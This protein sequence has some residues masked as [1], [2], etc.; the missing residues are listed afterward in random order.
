MPDAH[1]ADPDSKD[2]PGT[3][4]PPAPP[5]RVSLRFEDWLTV[6]TLGALACITLANVI[7]RYL[8]A[9][10]FAWTEEI[11]VFPADRADPERQLVG[12]CA[13][14]AHPHRAAGR[15]WQSRAAAALRPG[16]GRRV[17]AVLRRPDRPAGPHGPG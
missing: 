14:A 17:A 2:P 10:S 7:V 13:P 15:R 16:G 4:P 3:A 6:L 1:A 12:L 5:L 8:T 9:E 11:S